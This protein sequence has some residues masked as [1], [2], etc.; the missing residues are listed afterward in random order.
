MRSLIRFLRDLPEPI[1]D[2]RLW[3]LY[4]TCSLDSPRPLNSRIGSARTL[5]RLLPSANF[6]LLVYLLA[7]L[8][9]L[10]LV[11]PSRLTV[12]Q[13]AV[14]FGPAVFSARVNSGSNVILVGGMVFG[15]IEEMGQTR[16]TVKKAQDA[17][18]WLL[19]HWTEVS[20]DLLESNFRPEQ[21]D[22][23]SGVKPLPHVRYQP[24]AIN[25][26]QQP[27]SIAENKSFR[28]RSSLPISSFD[29]PSL[30]SI[31]ERRKSS[32]PRI[33]DTSQIPLAPV[34]ENRR[35]QSAF[36]QHTDSR[37]SIDPSPKTVA[38]PWSS[39]DRRREELGLI[40]RGSRSEGMGTN[41]GREER[42]DESSLDSD[43]MISSTR[44]WGSTA[45]SSV[46]PSKDQYCTSSFALSA[47][48][49]GLY[50]RPV[51]Q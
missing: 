30:A 1:L 51:P 38:D 46:E 43:G 48:R 17:L 5:L 39:E 37:A 13:I 11:E 9:Q 6:S 15:T 23:S 3:R 22:R 29:S 24:F 32:L 27:P 19:N 42:R 2:H 26:N 7:F 40:P 28:R 47:T 44:S 33:E 31:Q 41:M 25:Q 4:I 10:S 21:V 14:I 18:L 35:P 16:V 50:D 36:V 12:E 34:S 45:P 49:D 8:S 20:K